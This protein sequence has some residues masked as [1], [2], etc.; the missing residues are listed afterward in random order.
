[1]KKSREEKG[2]PEKLF[3]WRSFSLRMVVCMMWLGLPG[4]VPAQQSVSFR[5][6]KVQLKQALQVLKEKT[7]VNFVYNTKDVD[8]RTVVSAHADNRSPEEALELLLDRTPYVY[9]RVKDYFLI[10]KGDKAVSADLRTVR[11]VV[12]DEQGKPMPGVNVRIGG[13]YAGQSTDEQGR[14]AVSGL[15]EGAVLVFSFIGYK[16]VTVQIGRQDI[17][18]IALEPVATE[19]E[20]VVVTG[21][22]NRRAESFTGSA[23]TVKGDELRRVGNQNLLASLKNIDP[24]F[25]ITDNLEFGSDPNKLPEIQLR[26]RTS[27]PSLRGDYEGNP[28]QP[29][30]ILDG[31]ETTMEKVYDLNM[32][33]VASVTLLKDAAAKAIYGA[34]A[35]NGVVVIETVRPQEGRLRVS[36]TGSV[37]ITAPDLTSYNLCHASEKLQAEVLAG[38]Y[39]SDNPAEQVKLDAAYSELYNEIARGVDTY[40]LSQPLRT[41]VG[42]KHSLYIDGGDEAMRYSANFSYNRINGV[43]KGSDRSTLSGMVTLSY[44]YKTL[45]FRNN[46]S[47]DHNKAYNSPYGSFSAYA[48]MN[49]YL[50]IYDEKGALI[51][52]YGNNVYN[53]LYNATIGTKDYSTY[54]TVTENFYGEWSAMKNLKLTAKVGLTL[55]NDDSD[56]FKPA[57]HTDYASVQTGDSNYANR[58]EYRKTSGKSLNVAVDAGVNYTLEKRRHMLFANGTYSLTQ[59]R[60]ENY[61]TVA[62]GF[63]SDKLDFITA[64]NSYSTSAKPS[65]SESTVNTVGFTMALNY[66]YDN[67]YLA[68]ASWRANGSSQF[69]ANRRFGYFWS[70]GLG[71]NVHHEAFMQQQTVVNLLKIRGSVG[72]TGSQNFGAYQAIPTY[73]YITDSNYKGEIGMIL[74][75]LA[76]EDLQWQQQYDRNAGFDLTL[77]NRLSVR[78]DFYSNITKDLLT[79][80]SVVPSAGFSTYK[81]NLGETVNKGWQIGLNYRVYAKED[82][83]VNVSANFLHN[84]NKVRKIADYLKAYNAAIDE[85]KDEWTTSVSGAGEDLLKMQRDPSTRYEEGQSLSA[86]WAVRSL[87]ID[88]VTGQEIFLKRDG[89]TTTTTWSA[90]DQV[91]CG[92][93]EPKL[94][95]NFGLNAGWRGLAVSLAFTF[96]IGGQM[97][98]STLVN[99]IENVD[100][101][102]KN[103]DVRALTERWNTPGVETRFKGIGDNSTTKSTSR[104][105]ED[106]NELVLSSVNITYDLNQ[107]IRKMPFEN[108]RFTFNMSDIGRLSTMKQERGTAYPFARTFSVGLTADF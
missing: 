107:V 24:S 85:K 2:K 42:Q 69:G 108:V 87:G 17:L 74:G 93:T 95:G 50:R 1:M 22:F 29:L 14:F 105:V 11:G 101:R 82:L 41:G 70:A 65:G 9:E 39:T 13:T 103:V 78:T 80:I 88:P 104:F 51:K 25:V 83:Y 19:M 79:D 55:R 102:N 56:V 5:L 16:E 43:M 4:M 49:P 36:Y 45:L 100:V 90:A 18:E 76:N 30:F 66:S 59:T 72:Y 23:T 99:K 75:G 89:K 60:N 96:K 67:R 15:K 38:K 94:S 35:A 37:D 63:P 31:F 71:W 48:E 77:F 32:N 28:N 46:L 3:R 58:G 26:G 34:K 10:K 12:R 54:T 40:W 61:G 33:L 44:R 64:G 62:V 21:M 86:I 73:R 81:D 27:I 6:E 97:Y 84:T 106:L 47:V 91:V 8:D 92:D 53:P 57:S 68:D 20:E 98:N 52:D 7:G